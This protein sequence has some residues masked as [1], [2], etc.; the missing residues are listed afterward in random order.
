MN[1]TSI[2]SGEEAPV[3]YTIYKFDKEIFGIYHSLEMAM[4]NLNSIN[5]NIKGSIINNKIM[6]SG[7]VIYYIKE[8]R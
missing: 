8:Y 2:S 6:K 1:K 3:I 7:E 4:D 5:K